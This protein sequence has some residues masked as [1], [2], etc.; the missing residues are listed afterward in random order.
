[1][2][3]TLTNGTAILLQE[4]DKIAISK[5][6]EV[7]RNSTFTISIHIL[8]LG[9]NFVIAI[10][11]ARWLGAK[12]LGQYALATS[13]SGIIFGIVNFGIQGIL[14]REV[15]K[16]SGKAQEYLGNSLGIRL[17]VSFP[18][19]IGISYTMAVLMGF[20]GQTLTLVVLAS[21]FIGLTGITGIFYGVFHA[22]GKFEYQF[23]CNLVSK[24]SKCENHPIENT[25]NACQTYK[26]GSQNN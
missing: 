10:L 6:R 20:R 9:I 22:F 3:T 17:V 26:K 8:N 2:I 23:A 1:M 13:L 25:C 21:L 24:L 15:V 14:T 4:E 7:F 11:L 16:D 12:S 5:L 18:L 19:G